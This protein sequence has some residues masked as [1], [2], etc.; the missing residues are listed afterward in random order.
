MHTLQIES[1][2]ETG[3]QAYVLRDQHGRRVLATG[4]KSFAKRE[5][6]THN[7]PLIREKA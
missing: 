3:N 6:E 7:A 4:D 1:S 2:R 5:L